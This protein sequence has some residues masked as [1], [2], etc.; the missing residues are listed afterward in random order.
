MNDASPDN[1]AYICREYL[2]KDTRFR[3]FEKRK[4]WI[5]FSEKYWN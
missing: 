5:I 4:W 3:Y 1:S 2:A